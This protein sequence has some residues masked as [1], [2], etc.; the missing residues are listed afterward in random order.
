M[1]EEREVKNYEKEL[2]PLA[3]LIEKYNKTFPKVASY[4]QMMQALTKQ[5]SVLCQICNRKFEILRFENLLFGVKEETNIC[6]PCYQKH[7]QF[8]VTNGMQLG[9]HKMFFKDSWGQEVQL[10]K[11]IKPY[12][13]YLKYTLYP[14]LIAWYDLISDVL[15]NPIVKCDVCPKEFKNH[16]GSRFIKDD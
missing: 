9:N 15:D 8:V 14:N 11:K 7:L 13:D 4:M 6:E 1:F 10:C 12:K 3:H 2:Q 16:T 5:E